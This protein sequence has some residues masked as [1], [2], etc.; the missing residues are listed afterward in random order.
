V[1]GRNL[2]DLIAK[3][4]DIPGGSRSKQQISESMVVTDNDADG[5]NDEHLVR[6]NGFEAFAESEN[7]GNIQRF[8]LS[9]DGRALAY[10]KVLELWECDQEFVDFYLSIFR[11]CGFDSYVWE[12][13]AVSTDTAERPFEFVLHNTPRASQTPDLDTF[14]QYFDRNSANH[15]IVAFPN[16]GHDAILVVPS[17]Y[18]DNANYSGLADFFREAP[19]DQQRALWKVTAQQVKLNLSEKPTWVSVAGGGISWLHIRL[20]SRPKYYRY[21]PYND[22][23]LMS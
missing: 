2:A 11:K 9:E 21:M 10:R 1:S 15:G 6:G 20:D 7:N 17:P 19:I 12:T 4:R 14:A 8:R 5:S 22:T 3:W 13:P 16:L 18:R 23:C